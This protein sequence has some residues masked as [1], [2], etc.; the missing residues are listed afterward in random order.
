MAD[1]GISDEVSGFIGSYVELARLLGQRTGELHLA[2]TSDK[3]N[4][5]FAPEPFNPFYQRSLFQSIRNL[6][7]NNLQLLRSRAK[8]L[9]TQDAVKA[10]RVVA[11]QEQLLNRFKPL[12]Q[13]PI[14]AMRIRCHGDY[15]LGQVLYTGK[16]FMIIDF[17]GEPARP[18]GERRIKRTPLRDVAGMLRSFDYATHAALFQQLERG[19]IQAA[20]LP[21]LEPWTRYWYQW[22][23]AIFLKAYFGIISQSDL[24]P[25]D[26]STLALLLE[27]S[28]LEKAI[29]EV[30]YE[31]NNR[32]DWVR[33]PLDGILQLVS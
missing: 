7:V 8:T 30:G 25:K 32:P 15:H 29:Y 13:K 14:S 4:R 3:E 28:L 21:E 19:N 9:T 12:Y 2:L 22:V 1:A 17:E 18:L 24:V 26:I 16:D 33:I 10:E 6:T 31:L 20:Q 23:S 11:L 27:A 5:D